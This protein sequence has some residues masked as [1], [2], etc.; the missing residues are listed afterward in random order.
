MYIQRNIHPEIRKHLSR[1]EYTIITGAR[2]SGK[3]TLLRAIYNEVKNEQ[4]SVQFVTFEDRD[5][6]SAINKHPEEIFT[7]APRPTRITGDSKHQGKT[8]FLFIDE[9]QYADNPSNF[10]KYLFDTYGENLKIVATGSSAFYIDNKFTDS[11]SGRKRIFELQTLSF[12]EWLLFKDMKELDKELGTIRLQEDFHSTRHRELLEM[13]N[14]YLVFGGYPEVVLENDREEKIHLLKEIK[15]AFLKRD[16][17]ESGITNPDK[18][19]YLLSL[20][21]AQTG[22]MVNRNELSNTIGVDNKTIEK[23]LF[24]L[25]K[26]FHIGLV[27]PFYSNLRKEL[28]KMP[29]VYFKDLGMRNMALNRFYDIHSRDDQGAILESFVYKRLSGLFDQDNIKFWRTTDR[30]EI[31]FVVTTSYMKGIAY[32]V[33]MRGKSGKTTSERAFSATYPAYPINILSYQIEPG[34]RWVLKL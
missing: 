3:T 2:Q 32:E 15:N 31:D 19:Y 10:I 13:F 18:F 23:Y 24:V 14:E 4:Q 11:L 20:L 7:F 17:D 29:K 33:K 28:T 30:K 1:K 27:R 6:L 8:L 12:E 5:I 21:S 9:V 25:Q 22:N 16:I 34:C 26:C